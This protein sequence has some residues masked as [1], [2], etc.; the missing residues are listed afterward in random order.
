MNVLVVGGAGYLGGALTDML[1]TSD[2]EVRVFD[3]L[4]F[5]E[6]YLKNIPFVYGDVR[7]KRKLRE[8]LYWA[9]TVVW[10]AAMVGDAACK[11]NPEAT[12]E[13]NQDAVEW[14]SHH[15]NGQI[16]FISTCSVY[17]A[18][19]GILTE[20]SETNPL[21]L[22]ASSKLTAE[23]FLLP[24]NALVF[25]LGTLFGV[26]DRFTRI[27][28]DLVVNVLTVRAAL[29]NK[30]T[31][32][33]GDQFR[34][35]LHVRDAAWAIAQNIGLEHRGVYN[36]QRQSVRVLDLAYQIRNHFPD[37]EVEVT[38]QPFEDRRSYRVS[39]EK[40]RKELGFCTSCSI[41]DGIEELKHIITKKRV[42]NVSNPRYANHQF[43]AQFGQPTLW[44]EE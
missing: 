43:L 23:S 28:L 27:R 8:H 12:I 6:A 5:E 11:L 1:S 2:H 33:G 4:L 37:A 9:D 7:D 25:R 29:E 30:L 15:F 10:L 3:T 13:I 44:R 14:F 18:Q 22:Y 16:I 38:A 34:P 35:L 19:E 42:K 41:D 21:S 20:E 24:K 39:D 31:V 17:G 36:L 26:S 32:F 40:A